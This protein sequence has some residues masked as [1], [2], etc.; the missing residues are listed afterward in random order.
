MEKDLLAEYYLITGGKVGTP[1]T[2]AELQGKS[3]EKC[4]ILKEIDLVYSNST[5]ESIHIE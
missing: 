2:G 3:I 4:S 5:K 1:Y